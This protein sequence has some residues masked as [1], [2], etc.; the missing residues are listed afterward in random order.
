MPTDSTTIEAILE[1]GKKLLSTALKSDAQSDYGVGLFVLIGVVLLF[2]VDRWLTNRNA[3]KYRDG[4]DAKADKRWEQEQ[5]RIREDKLAAEKSAIQIQDRREAARDRV[6]EAQ[7]QHAER[8]ARS[9]RDAVEPIAARL[10]DL[11]HK[12]SELDKQVAVLNS[13]TGIHN[14]KKD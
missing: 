11:E 6:I 4:Q 13:W 7:A 10:G 9:I 12:Q 5:K 3:T 1:M 14:N 2:G 8:L